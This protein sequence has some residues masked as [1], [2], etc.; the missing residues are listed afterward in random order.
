MKAVILAG[1]FGTRFAEET[2]NKPKPMIEIGG[3][4]I[5]WHVMRYYHSFGISD[6][7]ICLGYKGE[8]IREYFTKYFFNKSDIQLSL[9]DG[10]IRVLK[11]S[12]E[13]WNVTLIDTGLHSGTASRLMQ[14]KDF[15]Q[16]EDQFFLTYSDGVSD[17]DL[18]KHLKFHNSQNK[19]ATLC[20]VRHVERFGV[21]EVN[22]ENLVVNF[23]EKASKS[24]VHKWV[25]GGFYILKN[26]IFGFIDGKDDSF[27]YDV[28]P[29]LSGA[30]ELS[31]YL[32]FGFWHPL[33]SARDRRVLEGH[34]NN[35]S[36][37]WRI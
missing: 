15:L 26:D 14:V 31:A 37:A 4:P 33:D 30:K 34:W 6:F 25:N 22:D 29:R 3:K 16:D 18:N 5:I 28:L 1:G 8:Y 11:S 24:D 10:S 32:H 36:P 13:P 7:I 35:G 20:A 9:K 17:L 27:E 2:D 19:V 23:D 21:L 12:A